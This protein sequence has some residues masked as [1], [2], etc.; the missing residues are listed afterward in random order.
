MT[1][2]LAPLVAGLKLDELDAN[3]VALIV[4]NTGITRESVTAWI[5]AKRLA[6]RTQVDH[7]S[8]Y[9]LVRVENTASL[10]RLLR[11]SAARLLTALTSAAESNIISQA[12]GE[13]AQATLTRLRQ[14]LVELS[15]SHETPGS[16]GLLWMPASLPRLH[17][18]RLSSRAMQTMK[19]LS[20]RF[21]PIYA[22][23]RRLATPSSM[24]CSSR[25]KS[26]SGSPPPRGRP[27]GRRAGLCRSF[28]R[29]AGRRRASSVRQA[30]SGRSVSAWTTGRI[31]GANA[32]S[33]KCDLRHR[34][35]CDRVARWCPREAISAFGGSP[36]ARS[37]SSPSWR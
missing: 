25:C 15:V 5:A 37:S 30:S 19:A 17:N 33:A 10:P 13:R 36:C 12:A 4:R 1:D 24:I 35:D 27:T 32:P 3:D 8:L 28:P 14:L 23:T 20:R 7:E 9:A 6:E 2:A 11:R 29:E 21:G 18:R 16:L 31:W 34:G 26:A 22:R